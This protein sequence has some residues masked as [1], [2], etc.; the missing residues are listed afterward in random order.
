MPH[1]GNWRPL[2][3]PRHP[4][5]PRARD[6]GSVRRSFRSDFP[7]RHLRLRQGW[8]RLAPVLCHP[9]QKATMLRCLCSSILPSTLY[10]WRRVRV[11]IHL[12]LIIKILL[13]MQLKTTNGWWHGPEAISIKLMRDGE[14]RCADFLPDGGTSRRP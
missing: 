10:E 4:H 14:M 3:C 6:L 7:P 5:G 1:R 2:R 13:C 11:S 8:R 9:G 12:L